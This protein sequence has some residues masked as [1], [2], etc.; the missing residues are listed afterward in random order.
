MKFTVD[1]VN[2]L[3]TDGMFYFLIGTCISA[4]T[5]FEEKDYEASYQILTEVLE[6]L[7]SDACLIPDGERQENINRVSDSIILVKNEYKEKFDKELV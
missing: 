2:K 3:W 7:Q 5:L 4:D 6:S 1:V